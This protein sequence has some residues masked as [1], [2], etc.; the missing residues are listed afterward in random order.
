MVEACEFFLMWVVVQRKDRVA[1]AFKII[2]TDPSVKV[3]LVNIFGGIV[4]CGFDY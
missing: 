1:E 3:I 4:R 2:L